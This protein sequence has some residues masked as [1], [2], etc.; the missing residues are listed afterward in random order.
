[1]RLWEYI[2]GKWEIVETIPAR[3]IFSRYYTLT[4]EIERGIK[5]CG[6]FIIEKNSKNGKKR[7]CFETSN[8]DRVKSSVAYIEAWKTGVYKQ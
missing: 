7:A 3:G 2:F 6:V 4:G 5:M 8:G 1:M